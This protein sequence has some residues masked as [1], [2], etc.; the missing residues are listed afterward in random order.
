MLCRHCIIFSVCLS[1]FVGVQRIKGSGFRVQRFRGC[2]LAPGLHLGCLFTRKA[3]VS[4]GLIQNLE[5]NWQLFG[6]WAFL[7]RAAGLFFVLNPEPVNGYHLRFV[8]CF[9]GLSGLGPIYRN[10]IMFVHDLRHSQIE[11]L[12]NS[13]DLNRNGRTKW[14]HKSSIF[15]IQFR[16]IRVGRLEWTKGFSTKLSC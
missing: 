9:S 7:T 14:Y 15:N 4:S 3:S 5:S 16:F 10:H 8:I 12:S 1:S 6:K 13:I 11:Y 2:I